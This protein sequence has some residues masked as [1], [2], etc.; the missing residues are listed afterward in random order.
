MSYVYRLYDKDKNII[1]VGKT[2]DNPKL[3]IRTHFGNYHT[4]ELEDFWRIKVR[5]FD[6]VELDEISA[7]IYEI[8][9]INKYKPIYNKQFKYKNVE[10]PFELPKLKFCNLMYVEEAGV[11]LEYYKELYEELTKTLKENQRIIS[12]KEKKE[13]INRASY[14]MPD[15]IDDFLSKVIEK[16]KRYKERDLLITMFVLFLGLRTSEIIELNVGDINWNK[17]SIILKDNRELPIPEVMFDEFEKYVDAHCADDINAPIFVSQYGS[18]KKISPRNIQLIFKDYF[19]L[20]PNDMRK[21]FINQLF[22]MS[23][24]FDLLEDIL[25]IQR[26]RFMELLRDFKIEKDCPK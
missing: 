11:D 8:Y 22:E 2:K 23:N 3:R 18:N 10:V 7:D 25:G 1:Y 12:F 21:Y 13:L 5:Y 4:Y 6:Y 16:N 20:T 24:D 15:I 26:V 9:L 19:G 17:K 14:R